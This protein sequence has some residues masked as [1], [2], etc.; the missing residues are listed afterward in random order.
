MGR[1]TLLSC[2]TLWM[3]A[4]C[5][6][7]KLGIQAAHKA[8]LNT[9]DCDTTLEANW[10]DALYSALLSDGGAAPDDWAWDVDPT[11]EGAGS[12]DPDCWRIGIE[13]S[14]SAAEP[15]KDLDIRFCIE[16]IDHL[17]TTTEEDSQNLGFLCTAWATE[18]GGWSDW[19]MDDNCWDFDGA[20]V[21]IETRARAGL[22]ITDATV[23]L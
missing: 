21:Q 18:G 11:T 15:I 3:V 19:R 8:D 13:G 1:I 10:G 14:I 22:R 7:F 16:V 12:N 4:K 9:G 2:I 20:R 17:E 5:A 6:D 23:G